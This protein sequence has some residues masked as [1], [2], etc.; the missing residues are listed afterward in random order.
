MSPAG[1]IAGALIGMSVETNSKAIVLMLPLPPSVTTV[2][3]DDLFR[4]GPEVYR[5]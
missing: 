2:K 4:T 3:L 1:A 5:R